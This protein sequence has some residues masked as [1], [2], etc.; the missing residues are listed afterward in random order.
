VEFMRIDRNIVKNILLK[1]PELRSLI[2]ALL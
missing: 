1:P 2:A